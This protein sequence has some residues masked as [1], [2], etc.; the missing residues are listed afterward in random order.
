MGAHH[1][2][3]R[4]QTESHQALDSGVRWRDTAAS[5]LVVEDEEAICGLFR[6]ALSAAGYL[7]RTVSTVADALGALSVDRFDLA[8]FDI[9]LPDGNGLT[10]LETCLAT[11]PD[12]P[13]V[14]ITGQADVDIARQAMRAGACDFISKPF[15]IASL[16]IIVERNVA[17][18]ELAEARRKT[19]RRQLQSSYETVLSALLTALDT[20][21]TETEGHSE[22]VTGY[23]MVLAE[24]LGV[25]EEELYHI[26]RGALLHDIGKIGVPDRILHKPGPLSRE[27]W[28]EMRRHPIIGHRMCARIDFLR[29]A[30]EIILHHHER[31]DGTGY[32]DRLRGEQIPLGARIFAVVD[33]FDAMTTDRT[34]RS[35][36][37]FG[38]AVEEIRGCAGTQFDPK[39]VEAFLTIPEARWAE[40][41]SRVK[42][43]SDPSR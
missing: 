38:E 23:T 31:W 36:R 41:K 42:W 10:L 29:G 3:A 13:I 32:P 11:H 40:V 19:H 37:P 27:E 30:S 7:V 20:R 34:Y 43:Y 22:R 9:H 14:M 4:A 6:H 1:N 12:V 35:A 24:A 8:F 39:V 15:P 16:P 28:E 26:E 2:A 21:D 18:N 33:A 5:V 17:R 25:S